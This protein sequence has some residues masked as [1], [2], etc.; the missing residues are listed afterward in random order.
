MCYRGCIVCVTG[1]VECVTG[2]VVCVTG[3][4]VCV[5]QLVYYSQCNV[6]NPMRKFERNSVEQILDVNNFSIR[7]SSGSSKRI[8]HRNIRIYIDLIA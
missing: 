2:A 4:V 7:K 8:L 6:S 5:L 1:V 3:A